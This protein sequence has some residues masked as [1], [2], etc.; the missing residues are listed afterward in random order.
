[1]WRPRPIL[2]ARLLSNI[3]PCLVGVLGRGR[4]IQ[5]LATLLLFSLLFCP[6]IA[7]IYYY[8]VITL[9]DH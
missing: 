1:M 2:I 3:A 5:K 7:L 8:Y 6:L 4:D 9:Q